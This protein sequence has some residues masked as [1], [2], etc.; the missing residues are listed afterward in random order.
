MRFFFISY[1]FRQT[2]GLRKQHIFI[3]VY[4]FSSIVP[5]TLRKAA[6]DKRL[7]RNV[8]VGDK[9]IYLCLDI[10]FVKEKSYNL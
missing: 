9:H 2:N 1:F 6:Q 4:C 7:N 8:I 10:P 3:S 5:V